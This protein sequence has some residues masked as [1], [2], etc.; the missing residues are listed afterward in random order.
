M[1]SRQP[2]HILGTEAP[3]DRPSDELNA[4]ACHPEALYPADA[5]CSLYWRT[6]SMGA[7]VRG[8]LPRASRRSLRG[9]DE[10]IGRLLRAEI[11]GPALPQ[12]SPLQGAFEAHLEEL[13]TKEVTRCGV[14]SVDQASAPGPAQGADRRLRFG[15]NALGSR[16]APG[17]IG[18]SLGLAHRSHRTAL[19]QILA[20]QEVEEARPGRMGP[21]HRGGGM[22]GGPRREGFP[23]RGLGQ[24]LRPAKGRRNR[25]TRSPR[26]G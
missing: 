19:N 5:T 20:H 1:R 25:R 23:Q 15:D 22:I 8:A 26:T 16:M 14:R 21:Q 11:Y 3:V 18:R 10:E 6:E 24:V 9:H 7:A 4:N 12:V 13:G 2:R 17:G